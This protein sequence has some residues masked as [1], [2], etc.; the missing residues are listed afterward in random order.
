MRPHSGAGGGAPRPRKPSALAVRMVKPMPIEVRTMIGDITF[1]STCRSTMRQVGT[2]S[3][4][5]ASMK[6]SFL[7]ERTSAWTRRV[8]HGQ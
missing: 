1:G 4:I 3:A 7:S 6:V 5:A 2:P 8:N